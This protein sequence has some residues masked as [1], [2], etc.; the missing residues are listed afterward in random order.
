MEYK[1]QVEGY[2]RL[3]FD[4]IFSHDFLN[5]SVTYVILY[6]RIHMK[7]V[8]SIAISLL[9]SFVVACGP[10][11]AAEDHQRR[12]RGAEAAAGVPVLRQG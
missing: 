6:R 8:S 9:S 12:Q 4:R 2:A 7:S 10:A 3:G 1:T 11:G 5:H